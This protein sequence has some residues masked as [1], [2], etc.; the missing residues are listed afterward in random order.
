[1]DRSHASDVLLIERCQLGDQWAF[2]ALMGR[3][4]AM[5]YQYALKLTKH[6]EE[7]RDVVSEAFIRVYRAI[8]QFRSSSAFTTWFYRILRN[9]FLDMR[10]RKTLNVVA[11]LDAVREVEDGEVTLQVVDPC[12]SPLQTAIESDHSERIIEAICQ[13]TDIQ[14]SMIFMYHLDQLTYEEI[15]QQMSLPV[16]TVKSRLNR[17]RIALKDV[18]SSHPD[19]MGQ[20]VT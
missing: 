16:G 11:S 13:L 18:L 7:A 17:A 10:K 1:M 2:D 15:A 12:P 8:G 4:E 19:L 20:R 5:A 14:K 6:A 9:C 3:Y